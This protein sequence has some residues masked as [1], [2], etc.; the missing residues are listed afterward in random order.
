MT[1]AGKFVAY[2]ALCCLSAGCIAP[3][4]GRVWWVFDLASHFMLPYWMVALLLTSAFLWLR[5][6]KSAAVAALLLMLVSWQVGPYVLPLAR[7]GPTRDRTYQV[8]HLNLLH[9]NSHIEEVSLLIE[10]S[11]ADVLLLQE[12]TPRWGSE[13]SESLAKMYP[14]QVY[15]PRS[16][17]FGIWLLSKHP[18]HEVQVLPSPTADIPYLTAEIDFDGQRLHLAAV[19]PLPPMGSA[20]AR[21]RNDLLAKAGGQLADKR[22]PRMILGDLN[23]TPWS[24]YFKQLTTTAQ[25]RD[26]GRWRGWAPT[27]YSGLPLLHLPIDHCLV[28]DEIKIHHRKVERWVGS[29]HR[30]LL[31]EFSF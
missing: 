18:L 25:V 16:H 31:V 13:L 7:E 6:W 12:V 17:A 4:I 1:S 5:C 24:P 2:F 26:S 21:L 28:S 23:C 10:Q 9:N 27:W 3:W 11:S 29:D 8:L 19:H 15:Q 22:G 20:R 14:H 30:P